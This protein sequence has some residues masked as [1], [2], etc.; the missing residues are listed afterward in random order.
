MKIE[1]VGLPVGASGQITNDES[2]PLHRG[3]NRAPRYY[4]S[5]L[6]E[7]LFSSPGTR[8]LAER[9]NRQG[10]CLTHDLPGA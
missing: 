4:Y 5:P 6:G 2:K 9:E 7:Y 8:S 1:D 10:R 3:F